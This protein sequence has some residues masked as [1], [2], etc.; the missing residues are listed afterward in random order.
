[1]EV[2]EEGDVNQ[3]IEEGVMAP[4]EK[5]SEY[6]NYHN[7]AAEA[8]P[9]K[10]ESSHMLQVVTDEKEVKKAESSENSSPEGIVQNTYRS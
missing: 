2:E 9:K 4:T 7:L 10:Q 8:A 3:E 5:D 1:M 6:F